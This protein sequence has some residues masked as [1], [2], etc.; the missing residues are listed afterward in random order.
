M[1]E[2]AAEIA[3]R[4]ERFV[5]EVVAPYERDPRRGRHGP[6][7]ELIQELRG[8]ARAAGVL[9]PHIL[10]DGSHLSQRETALVLRKSGLSSLGPIACNTMAPDEGNMFLLGKVATPEQK[11][12]FLAPLVSGEARSAFFMTEP[13]EENGAG[14]DPSM[15]KTLCRRDGNHWVVNGRK[16][17]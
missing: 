3:G 16:K 1:S 7:D 8:K 17:F 5:R 12:R 9:T 11:A 13:A 15:M 6:S 14:S 4:V 2:R 10:A